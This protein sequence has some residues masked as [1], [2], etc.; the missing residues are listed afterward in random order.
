MLAESKK[1]RSRR[2]C[3]FLP[4]L[5]DL[6]RSTACESF[7]YILLAFTDESTFQLYPKQ[8]CTSWQF[9]PPPPPCPHLVRAS[10]KS[11]IFR[12]QLAFSSRLLGFRSLCSTCAEWMYLS[13]RS[14]CTRRPSKAQQPGQQ[15]GEGS[16]PPRPHTPAP[17]APRASRQRCGPSPP[18][19][20]R[21]AEGAWGVPVA[22]GG[23][24]C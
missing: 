2:S 13:P 8:S 17:R 18:R 3:C 22:A 11:Q 1:Q 4:A 19:Q 5:L 10:P 9:F 20:P 16:L 12:S 14:T 21:E 23:L 6:L 7:C 24:A 15:G